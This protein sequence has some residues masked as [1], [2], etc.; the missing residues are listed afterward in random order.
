MS[1][2]TRWLIATLATLA[3]LALATWTLLLHGP[4]LSHD[5][6]AAHAE[7]LVRLDGRAFIEHHIE[8]LRA[9][10][11]LDTACSYELEHVIGQGLRRYTLRATLIRA[12]HDPDWNDWASACD[13]EH[14]RYFGVWLSAIWHG[15]HAPIRS[16]YVT[17]RDIVPA[18]RGD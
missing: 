18:T 16:N 14:A 1:D 2:P 11:H 9:N 5:R 8:H 13:D 12:E 6:A 17:H 15:A 10:P 4:A 3:T 7:Q